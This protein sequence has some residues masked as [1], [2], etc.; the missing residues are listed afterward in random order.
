MADET[1][2]LVQK[3]EKMQEMVEVIRKNK[4][5][6]KGKYVS[7]D[8]LLARI[9][10]GKKKYN[11]FLKQRIAPGTADVTH[12]HYTRQKVLKSGETISEDVSLM[13]V[14]GELIYTWID[15]DNPADV[16]EVSW[17]FVGVQDDPAQAFGSA[18]T[19]ANRYFQLKFFQIA[20]PED[21]PD[22]W[23][24]K[25]EE[26]EAEAEIA[27]AKTIVAKIDEY[28]HNY[29]EINSNSEE[30]RKTATEI[31]KIYVRNGNKPT[32]DYM[33]YLTDPQI[34]VKLLSALQEKCP[35]SKPAAKP[36][37]KKTSKNGGDE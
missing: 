12:I 19:Y 1:L 32:A 3:L 21:D 18:L 16:M 24:G 25:K 28:V 34:A 15:C 29:L 7:E 17:F 26:A 5:N 11:V 35:L 2:T 4:S 31:V 8:E 22:N 10:A 6:F 36:A 23:R 13:L 9:A 20:T 37:A 14:R 33:N 27:V 30:A